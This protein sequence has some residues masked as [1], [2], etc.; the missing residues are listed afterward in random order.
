MESDL[1][2]AVDAYICNLLVPP[3]PGLDAALANAAAAR[4]PAISVA[5]NQGKLLALLVQL[6][7]ARTV[8]E[9]G[10]LAG[11]ST[12]W[13]ARAMAP[14]G[15]LVTL[16]AD[17]RHA[18]V[19]LANIARAGLSDVVE[20]RLGA[21]LDTLPMLAAEGAGPFDLAFIDADKANNAEYFQWALRLCR[22]GTVIVVDNVVRDGAILDAT[23]S[24]PDVRGTRRLY[25]VMASESR[26]EATAIQTVGSK[27]YDGLAIALVTTTQG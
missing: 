21:A 16:E 20:V 6:R 22:P 12:I 15:R 4:L 14:G 24:D 11:Y 13:M 7:S 26:V 5:P 9:I 25:D 23:S 8:L 18:D 10:A 1:W 19:A 27:G 2:T 3:N 17:R